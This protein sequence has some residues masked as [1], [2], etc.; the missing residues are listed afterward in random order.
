MET[1][2]FDFFLQKSSK[3]E[4]WLL[5]KNWNHL[6]FVN[7]SPTL[8]IDTSMERSSRVLQHRKPI[9]INTYLSVSAVMFCKQ[10]LT[11]TVLIDRCYHAIH[12]HSCRTFNI[13]ISE[14]T[15]CTYMSS[16]RGSASSF[17]IWMNIFIYMDAFPSVDQK[18][19]FI[20]IFLKFFV[21]RNH[22]AFHNKYLFNMYISGVFT[23]AYFLFESVEFFWLSM[24]L[25][26]YY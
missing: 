22:V 5:T 11:Y 18:F 23:C 2:K 12:K 3:F 14:L 21:L 7:I 13:I 4:F 6:S 24:Q 25:I 20:S 26:I 9:F 8:V 1:Q 17:E 15:A 19:L 16:L 10:Y